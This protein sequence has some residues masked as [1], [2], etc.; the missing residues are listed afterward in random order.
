MKKVIFILSSILY[1]S[2]SCTTVPLSGRKQFNIISNDRIFPISFNQYNQV[3]S[4]NHVEI[5]TPRAQEVQRVGLRLRNA[6]EKYLDEQRQS[7]IIRGYRWTF[8]L[9]DDQQI[10]AWCMPGGKVVFYT[11]ILPVC[12]DENG[13]A[14]VMSH[15][16]AHALANHAAERMS[17]QQLMHWGKILGNV[18]LGSSQWGK[19][20]E[21]MYPA[22]AGLTILSYSRAQEHE[23]D[24]IGLYLMAMAGYDPRYAPDF[25]RRMIKA[26]A[27]KGHTPKFLSTH[28]DPTSRISDIQ[29]NIPKAMTY[30]LKHN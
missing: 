30:F 17:Q 26:T 23:A 14:V 4:K 6:V 12:K 9:I 7:E 2:Y 29:K 20:F 18:G 3:L 11:G 15:E 27:A 10:N 8:A 13:I 19:F 28:P 24:K 1:V 21:Q 22:V 25:W 16:I 5:R